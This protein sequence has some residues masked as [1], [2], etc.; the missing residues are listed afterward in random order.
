MISLKFPAFHWM[1]ALFLCSWCSQP[2][3][4]ADPAPTGKP[5]L[6]ILNIGD[7]ISKG[8]HLT[9]L[10]KHLVEAGFTDYEFVGPF[11]RSGKPKPTDRQAY[12]GM[13]IKQMLHGRVRD[14]KEE[15][16]AMKSV[17]EYRPN[18]I[19]FLGGINNLVHVKPGN[20]PAVEAEWNE[21]IDYLTGELPEA[22]IFASLV[23]AV[24]PER[25]WAAKQPVIDQFNAWV[26]QAV[27]ERSAKGQKIVLVDLNRAISPDDYRPDGLHLVATGD[28]KLGET[29]FE[30]LREHGVVPAMQA[31]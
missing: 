22:T 11:K 2:L 5:A 13:T 27:A 26:K 14:G 29:W 24:H 1:V 20:L 19:L 10:Q 8:G 30:A 16:G 12:G 3:A 18:V 21:L 23:I 15:P 31:K 6:R 9:A 17:P 28:A 25:K 4:A 7:S